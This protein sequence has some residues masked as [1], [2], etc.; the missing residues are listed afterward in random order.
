MSSRQPGRVLEEQR[1]HLRDG[2]NNS[3]IPANV[4]KPK[5]TLFFAPPAV[6][7]VSGTA[8]VGRRG[9]AM[10]GEGTWTVSGAVTCGTGYPRSGV[11]DAVLGVLPTELPGAPF[12]YPGGFGPPR[13]GSAGNVSVAIGGGTE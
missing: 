9:G 1:Q 4:P 8:E 2:Y 13:V 6:T 10:V 7:T 5:P 12:P 3:K 11:V